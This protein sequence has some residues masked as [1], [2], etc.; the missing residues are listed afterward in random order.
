MDSGQRR[1]LTISL[2]E[3]LADRRDYPFLVSGFPFRKPKSSLEWLKSVV[4][5]EVSSVSHGSPT[6]D[7]LWD[8]LIHDYDVNGEVSEVDRYKRRLKA[9]L[10]GR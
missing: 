8:E 6:E 1:A 9:I 2:P 4:G 3:I 7:E 10:N 5:K